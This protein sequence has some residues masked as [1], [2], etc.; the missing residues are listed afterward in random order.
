MTN[1]PQNAGA[2]QVKPEQELIMPTQKKSFFSGLFKKKSKTPHAPTPKVI[3]TSQQQPLP[4]TPTQPP[5]LPQQFQQPA[6]PQPQTPPQP[7]TRPPAQP[8]QSAMQAQPLQSHLAVQ[9]PLQPTLPQTQPQSSVLPPTPPQTHPP[10]QP[11]H[12]PQPKKGFFHKKSLSGEL[13]QI[14]PPAKSHKKEV[15]LL[16]ILLV[17]VGLLIGTITF[18][19]TILG[20]FS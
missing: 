16:L 3:S 15:M 4:S 10:Q 13:K 20:W 17:L 8:L 9:Q 19:D 12:T 1:N 7:P 5:Q 2:L 6:S 14:K 11:Q 18:R